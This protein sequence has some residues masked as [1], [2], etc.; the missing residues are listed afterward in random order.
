MKATK[1]PKDPPLVFFD[2]ETQSPLN[3]KSVG[4]KVYIESKHTRI[5]S[6][7]FMDGNTKRVTTW[8]PHGQH[9]LPNCHIGPALPPSI[10]RLLPTHRFVAHNGEFFDEPVWRRFGL[11]LPTYGFLDTMHLCRLIGLPGG[12]EKASKMLSVGGKTSSTAMLMLTQAKMTPSGH[13]VYPVGPKTVWEKMLAYN[14]Q[15]VT[16]LHDLCRALFSLL[17]NG[18][19]PYELLAVH[20]EI[21][22]RGLLVDRPYLDQ[23]ITHWKQCQK[24]ARDEIAEMTNGALTAAT[25]GSPK[26]VIAWLASLGIQTE[27][28]SVKTINDIIA[29]PENYTDDPDEAAFAIGV[30]VRRQDAVRAT[31]GKLDRIVREIEPDGKVRNSIVAFGAHTGRRSGRGIQVHNLPRGVKYNGTLARQ[32]SYQQLTDLV[33]AD[34]TKRVTEGKPLLKVSDVLTT[35]TRQIFIPEK[36]T[37]FCIFDYAAIEARGAA[38]V[39]NCQYALSLFADNHADIYKTMIAKVLGKPESECTDWERFI[40]KTMI[41]GLGYQM[42][43]KKFAL[44]CKAYGIDLAAVGLTAKQCVDTYRQAFPEIK[45]LWTSLNEAALSATRDKGNSYS[46]GRFSFTHDGRCLRL[47][48]PSGREIFYWDAYTERVMTPWGAYTDAVVYTNPHGIRR[49]LYGGLLLENGVQGMS[50]DFLFDTLITT[51]RVCLDVHDEV[52]SLVSTKTAKKEFIAN[53]CRMSTPPAWAEDF[54][55]KVAGFIATEYR[56]GPAK[57]TDEVEF[58]RGKILA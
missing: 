9:V 17:P 27:S 22:Q 1:D 28:V 15:D 20:R 54:P 10:L 57:K 51:P 35:L 58:Y 55:M 14:K 37:R 16:A 24:E 36:G 21:N 30:L 12:L 47:L 26:K 46:A 42:G 49:P 4:G 45:G 3:L 7:V 52:V 11:P 19:P 8:L 34:N 6:C 33:D 41:L 32:F 53:G 44:T 13:C 31:V 25:I 48:L 50:A 56:K 23:L 39:S 29:N 2:F 18:R 43:E 40:G 38:W 5:M